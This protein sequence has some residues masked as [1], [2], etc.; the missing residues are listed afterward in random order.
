MELRNEKKIVRSS[1]QFPQQCIAVNIFR[2][3]CQS[4]M[5]LQQWNINI[6]LHNIRMRS[7]KTRTYRSKTRQ[8][9]KKNHKNQC[10]RKDLLEFDF[11]FFRFT[12]F[13]AICRRS[14]RPRR[15]SISTTCARAAFRQT[16]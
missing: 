6:F 2:F 12:P 4:T 7:N 13:Y 14:A 1:S 15:L 11:I 9:K 5:S 3:E 16:L 8:K 10:H